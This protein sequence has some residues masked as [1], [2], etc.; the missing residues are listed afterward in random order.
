M[1]LLM[2]CVLYAAD[3]PYHIPNPEAHKDSKTR[4]ANLPQHLP[5]VCVCEG[6]SCPGLQIGS[7]GTLL[8]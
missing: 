5:A 2:P 3:V 8:G 1:T 6:V 4:Q 7:I